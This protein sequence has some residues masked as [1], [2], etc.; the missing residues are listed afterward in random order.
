MRELSE[1][2]TLY[3][4]LSYIGIC[5]C[6]NSVNAYLDLYGFYIKR[7]TDT[8]LQVTDTHIGVFRGSCTDAYKLHIIKKDG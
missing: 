4:D 5:I 8:E 2:G 7:L 1:L 3:K 6:Q